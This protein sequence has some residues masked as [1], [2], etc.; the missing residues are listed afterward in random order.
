MVPNCYLRVRCRMCDGN[1]LVKVMAL[2]P[3][4]PGN[5]FLTRDDLSLPEPTYPL[6]LYLCRECSHVQLG[7]VVDPTI[8]YQKSYSYRSATSPKF[9]EHLRDYASEMVRRFALKSGS[10]VADIGSNDGSCLRFFAVDGMKVVG[11]DPAVEIARSATESGV[12]TIGKFFSHQLGVRLCQQYGR[13]AL[14]TSHNACAHIDDLQGVFRG[15]ERWLAE[16]GV[17]VV[18][19]GYLLDVYENTWFDTIYHEHLDY[20]TVAPFEALCAR[21]GMEP[22]GVQRVSPQ[23]GSLR[24]FM[25]RANGALRKDGSIAAL[26]ER[27][28]QSHLD[29]GCPSSC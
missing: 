18:E 25:Q 4:P 7:H 29:R 10:L 2:T 15:V 3:T 8:L 17:F 13:A 16:D 1:R 27:E 19:V 20:H 5:N 26:V 14:I 22:I 9:L 24:V 28:R 21:V 12:E 6:D 11:V 23:G